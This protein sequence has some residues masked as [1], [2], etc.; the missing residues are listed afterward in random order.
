[1]KTF[2]K[3]SLLCLMLCCA[4]Q[5]TTSAGPFAIESAESIC[6]FNTTKIRIPLKRLESYFW[7]GSSCPL[8]NIV[9]VTSPPDSTTRKLFCTDPKEKWVQRAITYLDKKHA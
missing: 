8:K 9:L 3:T 7:T 4:L 5:L 2:M 1:M 6:C